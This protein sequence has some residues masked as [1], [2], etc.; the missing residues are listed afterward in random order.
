MVNV[1]SRTLSVHKEHE[2]LLKLEAAG[3]DNKLAQKI[4]D[5]KG[6]DLAMKVVRLIQSDG[7]EPPTSQ[8][9]AHEIMGKNYFGIKEAIEYFGVNP[10][11]QQLAYFAEVPFSEETLVASKGT[12]ILI[13]VF[14]M[15]ILDIRDIAKSS[16]QHLFRNQDCYDTQ[17]FAKDKGEI[18][19]QLV[20]KFPVESSRDKIWNEQQALLSE[21]E[22][23]P[24]AQVL[25]Y[26]IIGHFLVTG[27]RLFETTYV[28]CVDLYSDSTR[29]VVGIFDLGGLLVINFWDDSRNGYLGLSSAR[30][31]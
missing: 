12:H 23:I 30:K 29:V 27:E 16:G 21:D 3:L 6:N 11:K 19:W 28:R 17:A 15:S 1:V 2:V 26:T 22:E 13:A 10:T 5:S 4:I 24:K 7:Y 25:V 18:G 14:P 31:P 20:H 9:R 8:K